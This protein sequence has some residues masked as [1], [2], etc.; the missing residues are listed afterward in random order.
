M[1]PEDVPICPSLAQSKGLAAEDTNPCLEQRR[2]LRI[3]FSPRYTVQCMQEDDHARDALKPQWV[4]CD[5]FSRGKQAVPE[6]WVPDWVL[7]LHYASFAIT[8]WGKKNYKEF[9]T[10]VNTPA[11]LRERRGPVHK[12]MKVLRGIWCNFGCC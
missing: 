10:R 6:E 2:E 5:L 11:P 12:I 4:N 8:I 1:R 7:G 9:V 3:D